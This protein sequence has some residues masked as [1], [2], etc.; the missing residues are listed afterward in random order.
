GEV[1]GDAGLSLATVAG[2][3]SLGA[4]I[5]ARGTPRA[6]R[7]G[8]REGNREARDPPVE[9]NATPARF[10]RQEGSP[11]RDL[12]RPRRYTTRARR[13]GVTRFPALRDEGIWP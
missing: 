11:G 12:R 3:T 6:N 5:A 10:R 1:G 4:D 13:V 9:K 2:L 7:D 8:N